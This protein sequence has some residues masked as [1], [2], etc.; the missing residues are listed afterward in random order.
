[1]L[2]CPAMHRIVFMG[3]PDFAVPILEALI[4]TQQVVGVVTQPDR[5]SGRGNHLQPPP[6]K[7]VAEAAGLPVYQPKSLRK[8]EAIAPLRDWQPDAIVVAAFGQILRPHVLDLPPL[9]CLNV[10]ASLLPSW[11]GAAPIQHAILAGDAQS[12]VCLMRMDVGLDTGPVY[13]CAVLELAAD[14]TAATL[15]D[16][17]SALGA[18]LIQTELPAILAGAR[19]PQPQDDALA[20]YAPMLQKEDGRLAWSQSAVALERRVRAFTPWPGAYALWDGQP[21]KVL[22]AR[23]LPGHLADPGVVQ[24]LPDGAA[25]AT[26][27]GR[28]EL[29]ELQLP[30]KRALPIAEF[31]RGRPQLIG[32]R[33]E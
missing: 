18:Q 12:G 11:R 17:L 26:A 20:T 16:K 31:L 29:L 25:V 8:P 6:V 9:G 33:L 15:H 32:S 30:G 3:T 23:A 24:P 10:H 22:R 21:L 2:E 14:E 1:M 27:D 4:A 7:R 28:L 13:A 5:P 19:P